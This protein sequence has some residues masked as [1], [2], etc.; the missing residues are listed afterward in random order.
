MF[1]VGDDYEGVTYAAQGV[2]VN[3]ISN[4]LK[5]GGSHGLRPLRGKH[6]AH[7]GLLRR[8]QSLWTAHALGTAVA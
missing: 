3:T 5:A 7:A 6:K 8:P 4:N 1:A 2:V